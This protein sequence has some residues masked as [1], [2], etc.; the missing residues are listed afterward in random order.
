MRSSLAG[1]PGMQVACG[2][3]AGCCTSSYVIKIRPH[4]RDALANIPAEVLAPGEADGTRYMPANPQGHCPMY[5]GS[6]AN[7]AGCSI[8]EHRPE[9]CRT[10]DCRIF[11]A[12][13][14]PAGEGKT[15]INERIASWRFAYEDE[16]ARREHQAVTAVANYLR[17]HPVRFPNGRIPSRPSEIAVLAVKSYT[18][19]MAETPDDARVAAGIVAACRD[20][21][22]RRAPSG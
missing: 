18:V 7:D 1:G 9:T 10:Y 8:Y 17:Q 15:M 16:Q 5:S 13:G 12:A 22:A 11:S 6:S 2:D 19:F 3:C 20:F 4:E 14:M 21:D